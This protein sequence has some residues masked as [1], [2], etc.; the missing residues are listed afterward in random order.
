MIPPFDLKAEDERVSQ[1]RAS[2]KVSRTGGQTDLRALRA[3]CGEGTKVSTALSR[4][5]KQTTHFLSPSSTLPFGISSPFR[6]ASSL[7]SK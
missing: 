7:K 1:R 2:G 5:R 4:A 6:C 3:G